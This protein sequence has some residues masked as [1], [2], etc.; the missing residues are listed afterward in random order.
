MEA[1]RALTG[2]RFGPNLADIKA[3]FLFQGKPRV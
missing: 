2:L 1:T 3:S